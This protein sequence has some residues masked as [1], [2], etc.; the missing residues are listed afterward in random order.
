[1]ANEPDDEE[2]LRA[3]REL[4]RERAELLKRAPGAAKPLADAAAEASL[5]H[6]LAERAR[7]ARAE[8]DRIAAESAARGSASLPQANSTADPPQ[9]W[10][11]DWLRRA[12][13]LGPEDDPARRL[14]ESART[15]DTQTLEQDISALEKT[16]R[17]VG[18]NDPAFRQLLRAVVAA[19]SR[20]SDP[21]QRSFLHSIFADPP[22]RNMA[23]QE[24]KLPVGGH[25][26]GFSL[27]RDD[28]LFWIGIALFGDGVYLMA[29]HP[30]YA[31]P[32]IAAGVALLAWSNRG[33]MPRPPVRLA[34]L[35]FAMAVTISIAGSDY[36]D[37]HFGE[38]PQTR[39][40]LTEAQRSTASA[41]NAPRAYTNKTASQL[42]DL[43]TS[44][45][46]LQ[47]PS[48][49]VDE[50]GKWLTV[51]GVV[52]TVWRNGPFIDAQLFA[53]N[54]LLI[55]H[56]DQN[57]RDRLNTLRAPDTIKIAG[58]IAPT[59]DGSQLYLETCELRD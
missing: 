57:W 19:H 48:F 39:L 46:A 30:Y 59:Q 20:P 56:F 36:Y 1:M 4:G 23:G 11:L 43:C 45:T 16:A 10:E 49:F 8:H 6:S 28:A 3:L 55:C 51:E 53:D 37:R 40:P 26:E 35:I 14:A 5:R 44:R 29:E 50:I 52:R 24:S 47:C 34:V 33:H 31:I 17:E 41:P 2:A 27:S 38:K 21:P 15:A 12:F 25:K 9:R 58:K 42:L 54:R 32:L 7:L 13:G 22:R 18:V